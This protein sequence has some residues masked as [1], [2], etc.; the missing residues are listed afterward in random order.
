M[1]IRILFGNFEGLLDNT[2]ANGVEE[3]KQNYAQTR[4]SVT[5]KLESFKIFAI[6]NLVKSESRTCK[7]ISLLGEIVSSSKNAL[8][9]DILLSSTNTNLSYPFSPLECLEELDFTDPFAK[10]IV[11]LCILI[12]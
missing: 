11:N 5:E 2:V 12:L 6:Q 8:F 1:V 3:L 10:H 9:I 4:A 7:L